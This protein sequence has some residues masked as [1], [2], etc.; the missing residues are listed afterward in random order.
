MKKEREARGGL[1]CTV[2]CCLKLCWLGMKGV[3]TSF[4]LVHV[5]DVSIINQDWATTSWLV[6][7]RAIVQLRPCLS[8]SSN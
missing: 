7:M 1:Y 6:T 5:S 3:V 4:E 2:A 8:F